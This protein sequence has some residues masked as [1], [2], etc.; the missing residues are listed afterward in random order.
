[1]SNDFKGTGARFYP[2]RQQWCRAHARWHYH[3]RCSRQLHGSPPHHLPPT[4]SA[5]QLQ[6]GLEEDLVLKGGVP[7]PTYTS[8][9]ACVSTASGTPTFPVH[10]P[11]SWAPCPE[12]QATAG[13]PWPRLLG[14]SQAFSA[15]RLP[16]MQRWL[17]G[18]LRSA[19]KN[20]NNSSHCAA[21]YISRFTAPAPSLGSF[22]EPLGG[23]RF[24]VA[25]LER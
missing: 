13:P 23:F 25:L 9:W 4:L 15:C 17:Q 16:G 7:I 8:V 10:T 3:S 18:W 5:S 11:G 1:M 19:I 6:S 20:T 21:P 2:A 12:S 14:A 22:T 24:L